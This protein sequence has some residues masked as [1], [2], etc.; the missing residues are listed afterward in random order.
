MDCE[1][2][3]K[4]FGGSIRLDKRTC[5]YKW[6]LYKKEDILF[7]YAYLKKYPLKSIKKQRV[8]LI[9]IFF[10][11]RALRAYNHSQD[12]LT[13]KN[14]VLFEKQWFRYNVQRAFYKRNKFKI[15]NICFSFCLFL[16]LFLFLSVCFSLS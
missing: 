16:V 2:F 13:Y 9:P 11:L 5:T 14:W 3:Q 4:I 1:P 8:Q 15:N 10:E 12:S 7:F 6:E